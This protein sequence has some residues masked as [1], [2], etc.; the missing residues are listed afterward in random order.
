MLQQALKICLK[1]C[2]KQWSSDQK[3]CLLGI[4]KLCVQVKMKVLWKHHMDVTLN[5]VYSSKPQVTHAQSDFHRQPNSKS[6][7][8]C[9]LSICLSP[10][11][12]LA[13][14]CIN[15]LWH[16]RQVCKESISKGL[17]RLEQMS[18]LAEALLLFES[19]SLLKNVFQ[20]YRSG[21]F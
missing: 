16:L 5:T 19:K 1:F 7:Y 21:A 11:P 2:P 3:F 4:G 9:P 17:A 12:W 6:K 20:P 8:S 18:I 13:K 15:E 14:W 10:K